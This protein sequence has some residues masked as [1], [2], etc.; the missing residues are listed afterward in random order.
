MTCERERHSGHRAAVSVQI[1]G[2][3]HG[4]LALVTRP[5]MYDVDSENSIGILEDQ[6]VT[7]GEVVGSQAPFREWV[8]YVPNVSSV[9][10]ANEIGKV[11]LND[12]EPI[13]VIADFGRQ[14]QR[15]ALADQPLLAEHR[16]LPNQ[17]HGQLVDLHHSG[18]FGESLAE[19]AQK[20]EVPPGRSGI[21]GESVGKL[22]RPTIDGAL[23]DSKRPRIVPF[24][25]LCLRGKGKEAEQH[26]GDERGKGWHTAISPRT[27]RTRRTV[28]PHEPPRENQTEH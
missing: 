24:G 9:P 4:R 2:A 10:H 14:E 25:F 15:V 1:H 8:R 21:V 19:L 28:R 17:L 20:G 18:W 5:H 16:C 3:D 13:A 12:S 26:S 23:H 7:N 11:V 6:R 27:R 22:A